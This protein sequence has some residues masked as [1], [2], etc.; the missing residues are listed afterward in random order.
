MSAALNQNQDS[1]A[2]VPPEKLNDPAWAWA[3]YAPDHARPWTLPLAGHLYRRAAFGGSWSQLRQALADGPQRTIDRLLRPDADTAAFNRTIDDYEFSAAN[4]AAD[5]LRAWWLRRM[6]QTTHPLLETMTLFWHNHFAISNA[7][8]NN[9]QLMSR[10]VRHLRQ[11]ALGNF[12][13]LLGGLA[14]QP[15]VFL[16]LNAP[17]NRA[18]R[19]NESLPRVLMEQFT[20]GPG[21]CAEEDVREAARAFTGCF[22]LRDELR[23]FPAE[24]DTGVKKLL[25]QQGPFESKDVVRILLEQPAT[26]RWLAGRLYRWFISETSPPADALVKSLAAGFAKD[27]N[28]AKLVETILRSNL[29]FSQ[30]AYRQKIKSPVEFALSIVRPLGGVVGT[31]RLG[32]DLADL[33]MDL[34]QPPTMTGWAGHRYWINRFT[35][36][37]RSRLAQA[38]LSSS[39]PYESK[40]DPMSAAGRHGQTTPE[41]ASQFLID[42]FLQ[43]DVPAEAR[44]A[45]KATAQ[46][47]PGDPGERI[48]QTCGLIA[49]LP[50]FH[51]A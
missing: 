21:R 10:H 50:E 46:T 48:R 27:Y 29:F 5:E 19:P 49:S 20:L 4:T 35:L 47:G 32:A 23:Y 28:V 11:H 39:G 15:G 41:A 36:V 44:Q 14:T 18:A 30:A 17:A 45:A 22:V 51:L 9:A 1:R 43:G 33:G 34:Y 8:V 16:S 25:G 3:P 12:E 42:L 40:V 7:R 6:L 24:H 31:T 37:G 2:A 26:P 13:A 38:L